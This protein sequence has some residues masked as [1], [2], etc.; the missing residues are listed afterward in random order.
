MKWRILF[1]WNDYEQWRDDNYDDMIWH[2]EMWNG[3]EFLTCKLWK[4]PYA[5]KIEEALSGSPQK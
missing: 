3:Y 2:M 1:T 4:Q 5:N